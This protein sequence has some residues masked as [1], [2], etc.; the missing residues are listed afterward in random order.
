MI[1]HKHTHHSRKGSPTERK[2]IDKGCKVKSKRFSANLNT[3]GVDASR[4][5][6]ESSK[7]NRQR[8]KD[9]AA[10]TKEE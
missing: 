8:D 4:Q 6:D 5:G 2:G 9:E 7:E 10:E 1:Q 3:V